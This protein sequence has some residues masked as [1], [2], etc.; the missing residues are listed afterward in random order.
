MN[1]RNP[2]TCFVSIYIVFSL[3]LLSLHPKISSATSQGIA[4]KESLDTS[5]E[6][7]VYKKSMNLLKKRGYKTQRYEDRI[8]QRIKNLE[9]QRV[10]KMARAIQRADSSDTETNNSG[11]SNQKQR[12]CSVWNPACNKYGGILFPVFVVIALPIILPI[13]IWNTVTS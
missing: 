9:D 3:G 5:A 10:Q 13:A 12:D 11:K 1:K 6:R 2:F 4:S 8:N 7:I